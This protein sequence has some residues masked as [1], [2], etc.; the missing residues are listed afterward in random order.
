MACARALS[1][2]VILASSAISPSLTAEISYA[3]V[4]AFWAAH[5]HR[6]RG[7]EGKKRRAERGRRLIAR[8]DRQPLGSAADQLR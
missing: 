3:E 8:C 6:V 2:A 4:S 1:V 7:K 5:Q